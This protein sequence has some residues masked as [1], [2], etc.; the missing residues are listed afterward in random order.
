MV[1]PEGEAT[2]DTLFVRTSAIIATQVPLP[3]AVGNRDTIPPHRAD[4]ALVFV[5]YRGAR[6]RWHWVHSPRGACL[7]R[8]HG[9]L[10]LARAH[11]LPPGP[12]ALLVLELNKRLMQHPLARLHAHH[13]HPAALRL[14]RQFRHRAEMGI[15]SL[16]LRLQIGLVQP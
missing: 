13:G 7:A 3:K 9:S 1:E 10:S 15:E 12:F 4:S 5:V 14:R 11:G 2:G 16:L 6:R 8:I